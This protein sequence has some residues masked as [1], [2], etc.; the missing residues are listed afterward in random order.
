MTTHIRN[1]RPADRQCGL[2]TAIDV[3]QH[4]IAILWD[5]ARG[6]RDPRRTAPRQDWAELRRYEA[7]LETMKDWLEALF[8]RACDPEFPPVSVAQRAST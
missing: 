1:R 4:R 8:D 6:N 3:H 5:D 7:M 2:L